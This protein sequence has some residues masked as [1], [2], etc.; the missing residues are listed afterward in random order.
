MSRSPSMR[1]LTLV[2]SKQNPAFQEQGTI[3]LV[4]CSHH[5]GDIRFLS[6]IHQGL[7]CCFKKR[8]KKSLG[9][10]LISLESRCRKVGHR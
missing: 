1:P 8:V 10:A 4:E 5:Q 2:E 9:A 3:V 7:S 6:F